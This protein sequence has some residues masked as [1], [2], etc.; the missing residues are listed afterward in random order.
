MFTA[1]VE[2]VP[3]YGCG[4]W[5]LSAKLAKD[6][7]GTYTRMLR[8][9]FNVYWQQ[10]ITNKDL[11]DKLPT[12]AKKSD[13]GDT[14]CRPLFRSVDEP[15]SNLVSWIPKN[16]RRRPGKPSL[17]YIDVLNKKPNF[18]HR[19]FRQ[20]WRTKLWRSITVREHKQSNQA[21]ANLFE[22]LFVFSC[23]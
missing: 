13:K 10:H 9:V 8:T 21:R 5:T 2:S 4:A 14:F 19:I 15:V 23:V 6:L 11:Y 20:S 3:F 12:L 17:T 16:G 7:D 1:T 22:F 18:R